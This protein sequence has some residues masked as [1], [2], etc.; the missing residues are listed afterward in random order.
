MALGESPVSTGDDC[1]LGALSH[2]A[3][4]SH[5]HTLLVLV[6]RPP[7]ILLRSL[8]PPPVFRFAHAIRYS[9]P[10]SA[11]RSGRLHGRRRR[12]LCPPHATLCGRSEGLLLRKDLRLRHLLNVL[13][14][15]FPLSLL[16]LL[17]ACIPCALPSSCGSPC[18]CYTPPGSPGTATSRRAL[19]ASP[20]CPRPACGSRLGR[21]LLLLLH[22]P[23]LLL[24]LGLQLHRERHVRV[25][26][27]CNVLLHRQRK[28]VVALHVEALLWDG[29]VVNGLPLLS[30]DRQP[31]G[32]LLLAR[33]VLLGR[34]LDLGKGLAHG[35]DGDDGR[36]RLRL[37]GLRGL[38]CLV[39]C[40]LVATLLRRVVV[41]HEVAV[42]EHVVPRD[43]R[44][45]LPDQLLLVEVPHVRAE[46]KQL[47]ALLAHR[48][49]MVVAEEDAELSLP[50]TR[51]QLRQ[52][53]I[54]QL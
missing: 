23:L 7:R 35:V 16:I 6:P 19:P 12:S 33:L 22:R 31:H 20:A 14:M 9:A 21:G 4:R 26:L 46:Q 1:A 38:R 48:A 39:D 30:H 27:H 5:D 29:D 40:L 25:L 54:R 51:V 36:C 37:C 47:P 24:E 34:G 42:A 8:H 43:I 13:L 49:E 32:N 53:I 11:W 52:A 10:P 44:E 18:C 45:L 2:K 17:Q 50:H 28:I 41:R 3:L 15:P